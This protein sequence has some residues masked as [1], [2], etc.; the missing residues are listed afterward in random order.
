MAS[1]RGDENWQK[2][3][4]E[5]ERFSLSHYTP[6]PPKPNAS[7]SKVVPRSPKTDVYFAGPWYWSLLV[8][9]YRLECVHGFTTKYQ[10]GD[11]WRTLNES[12]KIAC[13]LSITEK[14]DA[15]SELDGPSNAWTVSLGS[16][17]SAHTR[18]HF[19]SGC[20]YIPPEWFSV[21]AVPMMH[22][23]GPN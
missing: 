18:L 7:Y 10:S 21:T 8:A 5:P 17:G 4:F 3:L 14:N 13:R 20:Q 9:M 19:V 23:Y 1:R 16:V 22:H 2:P 12:W 6:K 15:F 11:W